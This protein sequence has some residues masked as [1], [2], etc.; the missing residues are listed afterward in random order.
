MSQKSDINNLS[1][2]SAN[3]DE[4]YSEYNK[5]TDMEAK[6]D[7]NLSDQGKQSKIDSKTGEISND[8]KNIDENITNAQNVYSPLG[9]VVDPN[10]SVFPVLKEAFNGQQDDLKRYAG[11]IKDGDGSS[12][13]T[14]KENEELT[15]LVMAHVNAFGIKV[16]LSR[17]G[18]VFVGLIAVLLITGIVVVGGGQFLPTPKD[19]APNP[20]SVKEKS[21]ENNPLEIV[22]VTPATRIVDN[23]LEL[24]LVTPPAPVCSIGFTSPVGISKLPNFGPVLFEWTAISST[25]SY[26][27]KVSPPAETSLPWGY[28]VTENSKTIYMENF[29]MGGEFSISVHALSSSGTILCAATLRYSKEEYA[30]QS[31]GNLKNEGQ[32]DDNNA[33]EPASTPCITTGIGYF[34]P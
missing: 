18:K 6:Q 7:S 25:G 10:A 22:L 33:S 21:P 11:K 15:S 1:G 2:K 9:G 3:E 31:G 24:V 13:S 20:G 27:L 29:P 26:L 8:Q 12:S 5:M 14:G 32:S 16:G 23:P 34:C 30:N 4:V 19:K 28:T 17:T